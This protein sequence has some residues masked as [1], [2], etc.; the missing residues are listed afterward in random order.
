MKPKDYSLTFDEW[1]KDNYE[2]RLGQK[3]IERVFE[4]VARRAWDKAIEIVGK[5]Y[6][7]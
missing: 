1:W 4:E 3:S 2:N 7:E 6:Y 5:E